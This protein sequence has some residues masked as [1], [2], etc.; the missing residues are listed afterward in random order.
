MNF[1]QVAIEPEVII[2]KFITKKLGNGEWLFV[3]QH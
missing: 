1:I 2:L 3:Y